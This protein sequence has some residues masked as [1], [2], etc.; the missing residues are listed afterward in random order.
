MYKH[1]IFDFGGVFLDLGGKHSGVPRDLAGIFRITEE[2]AEEYWDANKKGML[3]GKETAKEFLRRM[4]DDLGVRIDVG[5]ACEEWKSRYSP[6]RERIDWE[7]LD[8]AKRLKKRYR[9]HILTDTIDLGAER[10]R[11]VSEVDRHFE[12]VFRSHEEGLKKPDREAFLNALGKIR[13]KPEECVFVD[14]SQAN[15]DAASRLGMKGI[16]YTDLAGLK[17]SLKELGIE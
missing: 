14:D 1:I 7:L 13:A 6:G 4:S 17:E 2:R 10:G 9:V 15:V 12:N 16:K 5:M 3:T 11:W 8:Y